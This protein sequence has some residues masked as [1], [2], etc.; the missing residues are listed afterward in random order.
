ML[1]DGT[2]LGLTKENKEWVLKYGPQKIIPVIE[3]KDLINN[4]KRDKSKK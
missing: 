2:T 4:Y 3:L 1:K